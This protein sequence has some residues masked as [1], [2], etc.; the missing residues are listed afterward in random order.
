M[1]VMI[2]IHISLLCR[3]FQGSAHTNIIMEM[4]NQCFVCQ[5]QFATT[6]NL[7]CHIKSVH[8]GIKA[9]KC[10]VCDKQFAKSGNMIVHMRTHSGEKPYKC[11]VC[12]KDFFN[13]ILAD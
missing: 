3:N 11:D 5:K 10:S 9:Y 7:M 4:E 13:T 1:P 2:M 12:E 8:E 6:K